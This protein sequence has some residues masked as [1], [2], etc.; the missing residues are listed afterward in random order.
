MNIAQIMEIQSFRVPD[1][2]AVIFGES[3]YTYRFLNTE[4]NRVANA[5]ISIGIK[6]GDHVAIWLPN[7]IEFLTA[8]Y[9]ILK[10][11]AVALPMNILFKQREMRFLLSNSESKAILALEEGLEVIR[12]IRPE[13]PALE[14][15]IVIGQGNRYDDAV[16][17]Q[18]VTKKCSNSFHSLDL[19]PDDTATILYTSGT[20]G[21]PKGAMLSHRN[22]LM[23]AE[24][25][26][27]AL[28]AK[29]D[30]V[31]ICV[32]PLSHLLSLAAG[33]LVLFGRGATMHVMEQF[34]AVAAARIISQHKV[35]Y[36]FAVR[37]VYTLLLALPDKPRY[38]LT[39]L[40]VCIVTGAVTPL[41]LRKAI[42]KKT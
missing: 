40:K 9:G 23:N 25:Y 30:W 19:N 37:T 35:N 15:V 33:V 5:L 24:Y 16:S 28:G 22:L 42:E 32:L 17:F 3:G 4:T 18:E 10:I 20:T 29:E 13:L 14:G 12:Q 34:D 38:E 36:T 21:D 7:C 27:A 1:K 2:M 31:G 8:F 11:G 41:E 6:K 39:S 26:A